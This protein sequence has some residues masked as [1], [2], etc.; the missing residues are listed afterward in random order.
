MCTAG[1]DGYLAIEGVRD[2][3]QILNDGR[4]VAYCKKILAELGD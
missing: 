1:Y 4:S 2:G 3:D